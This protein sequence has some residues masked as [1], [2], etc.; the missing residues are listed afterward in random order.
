VFAERL[1]QEAPNDISRQVDLAY[2]IALTR[3]PTEVEAAIGRE[4]VEER[5]LVDLT[6]VIFNLNEFLYL[7]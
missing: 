3:S 1:E 2:R 4:L 6:H 7:R 5:S